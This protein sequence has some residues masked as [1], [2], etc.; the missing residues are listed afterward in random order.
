MPRLVGSGSRERME[1]KD[2][3][4]EEKAL[5]ERRNRIRI[6][7]AVSAFCVMT[8]FDF[9]AGYLV[10]DW[11]DARLQ[12]GGHICR[13][14]GLGVAFLGML[15]ALADLIRMAMLANRKEQQP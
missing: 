14:V 15:F 1:N 6:I 4:R 9:L 12:T 3:D 5:I 13:L 8:V 11:L 10:G 7:T 2:R